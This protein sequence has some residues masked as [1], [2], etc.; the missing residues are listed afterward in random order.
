MPAKLTFNV[1][2]R[3][4]EQGVPFDA[5]VDMA[6]HVAT[7]LAGLDMAATGEP[8]LRWVI[9]ELTIG[10]AN[11]GLE[12]VPINPL[13]DRSAVVVSQFASG[14][15]VVRDHHQRPEWFADDV[16][17][18]VKGVIQV[19]HDGIERVT[20]G[21]PD[22][23]VV[24]TDAIHLP[25]EID[26]EFDAQ[27]GAGAQMSLS[28]IEGAIED[29]FGHDKQSPWFAIWDRLY[30]RRVRCEFP[31]RMWDDVRAGLQERVRVH[32]LVSFDH[33]GRPTSVQV[34]SLSVLAH[35]KRRPRAADLYGLVP[36]LTGG[37][38]SDEWVRRIRDA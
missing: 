6:R 24:L 32:G 31:P 30:G 28:S 12:A 15:A 10:S 18:G 5:F 27:A 23:A 34:R 38:P 25:E 11:V 7:M 19:L 22:T 26:M 16:W 2:A 37:L 33:R 21:G 36:G 29:V 13:L 14:M 4:K 8:S 3:D 9:R 1:D 20:F 35:D 17:D